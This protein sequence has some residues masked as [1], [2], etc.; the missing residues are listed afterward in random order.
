VISFGITT[1][2]D[3]HHD[4]SSSV[5]NQAAART[6]QPKVRSGIYAPKT[7]EQMPSTKRRPVDRMVL[8]MLAFEVCPCLVE[9]HEHA[10]IRIRV[11]R[12]IYSPPNCQRAK[13]CWG[14]PG[15]SAGDVLPSNGYGPHTVLLRSRLA[16]PHPA[17]RLSDAPPSLLPQQLLI[18]LARG[19]A[20]EPFGVT[21]PPARPNP[22]E[23][24]CGSEAPPRYLSAALLNRLSP[25][26]AIHIDSGRAETEASALYHC[27]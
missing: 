18:V 13:C 22:K 8:T 3:T 20:R 7:A 9:A 23:E 1:S 25:L 6:P 15:R 5:Y 19:G 2:T 14:R 12:R 26:I 17:I 4:A 27:A 11:R 10:L 16:V 21:L 24:R